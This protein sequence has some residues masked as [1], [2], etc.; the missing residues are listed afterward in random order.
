[1]ALSSLIW[2]EGSDL[3][4][5]GALGRPRLAV[6]L[7]RPVAERAAACIGLFSLLQR[8]RSGTEIAE[9]HNFRVD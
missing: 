4:K 8:L 6:D 7:R 2:S 5:L 3:Q 1:M 9:W